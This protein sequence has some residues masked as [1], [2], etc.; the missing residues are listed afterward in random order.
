VR[1]DYTT[2]HTHRGLHFEEQ[3]KRAHEVDP[4]VVMIAGWNEWIAGRFIKKDQPKVFAGRPSMK[5]GT[6]FVDVFTSEFSRDIAPMRGGYTDNYYY[7]MVGHIRRFKGLSPPPKRPES[8]EIHIDGEFEDWKG[9]PAVHRDPPGDTMHRSFRGTDPSTVYTNT[10]GRND[11][12]SACAVEGE[13]HVHFMVSAADDLTPHTDDHWMILLIDADQDKETGWQGYDRA[14]NRN[15]LSASESVCAKWIDGKWEVSG[16]VAIGYKGK[17]L[18]IS[19]PNTFFP[20]KPGRGFDFKWIDNVSL[21][22]VESLFL[23]GDAAPDRRF[24][25]RY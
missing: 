6:W 5:D 11:I 18:E 22:S 16:K 12:L 2:E 21:D 15:A 9:V 19:V 14:V 25:F 20:R 10:F 23:E 7:Q 8:R 13:E 3:W 1:P 24:D 4:K 17:Q